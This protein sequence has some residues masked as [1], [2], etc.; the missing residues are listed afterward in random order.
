M[1][2]NKP[3]LEAE[4]FGT[5]PLENTATV[6]SE[7][8]AEGAI[9]LTEEKIEE[10]IDSETEEEL[11]DN[12]EV[13]EV[14]ETEFEIAAKELHKQGLI[15]E[16]PKGVTEITDLATYNK[17]LL[18]NQKLFQEEAIQSV[19][20]EL[21]EKLDPL[22][23]QIL[24]FDLNRKKGGGEVLDIIKSLTYT[25]DISS[26]DEED[27]ID[28]E[29]IIY[30]Y[31]ISKNM[32]ESEVKELVATYKENSDVLAKKAA[33]YKPKLV[34]LANKEAEK[35]IEQQRLIEQEEDEKRNYL[36]NKLAEQL[37]TGVIGSVHESIGDI[38]LDKED[39]KWLYNVIALDTKVPLRI[40]GKKVEAEVSEALGHFHKYS[41]EGNLNAYLL[42]LLIQKDPAKVFD[43]FK[44]IAKKE[45]VKEIRTENSFGNVGLSFNKKKATET[46]KPEKKSSFTLNE[47][48]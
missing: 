2:F 21:E 23:K 24:S 1:T 20:E 11:V 25:Y 17:V 41:K 42:S 10:N 33:A 48:F 15:K 19:Y 37:Q 27:P 32:E 8:K 28:Q 16:L 38:P 39:A 44:K 6:K 35:Q 18:H 45:V 12:E 30:Q 5:E 9:D 43:H 36:T 13:E 31:L 34:D 3:T 4:L 46:K 22:T 14:E 26:L 7:V 40:K 47:L 29:E